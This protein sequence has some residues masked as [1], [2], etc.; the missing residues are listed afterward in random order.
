MS[1][2]RHIEQAISRFEKAL[3]QL[4]TSLVSVHEKGAQLATTKGEA[5]ALRREQE[6]LTRELAAVRTKAD[7]LADVNRRAANRLEHA[8]TRIRKVLG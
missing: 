1:E 7:E 8:M 6:R 5:E 2:A 3:H 4:E